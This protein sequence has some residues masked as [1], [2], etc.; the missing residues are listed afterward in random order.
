MLSAKGNTVLK[1]RFDAHRFHFGF[2]M[3]ILDL[4]QSGICKCL[5]T[6]SAAIGARLQLNED[7]GHFLVARIQRNVIPPFTGFPVGGDDVAVIQQ[8][9]QTQ[10]QTMVEVLRLYRDSWQI[11]AEACEADPLMQRYCYCK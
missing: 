5:Q 8:S 3:P 1:N 11:A 9:A 10:Q 4:L 2:I 6:F 7:T